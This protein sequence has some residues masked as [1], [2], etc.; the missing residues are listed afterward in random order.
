MPHSVHLTTPERSPHPNGLSTLWWNI[1]QPGN[2]WTA[3]C[4]DY[5]LG[6]SD[7][8]VGILMQK[9]DEFKRITWE[10]CQDLVS[11]STHRTTMKRSALL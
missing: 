11:K 4:P 2:V 9:D 3:E 10:K 7:K 5:L 1:N 6:Q 8:N